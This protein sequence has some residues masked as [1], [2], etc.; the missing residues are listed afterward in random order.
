MP[1]TA[2][3]TGWLNQIAAT[4][5]DLHAAYAGLD[6]QQLQE[7][8]VTGDWSIRDILA[9]IAVWDGEARN[10]LPGIA[11]GNEDDGEDEH[12]DAFNA[13]KTEEL[14]GMPLDDVRQLMADTH[15]QLLDY[16]HGL[17]PE[18]LRDAQVTPFRERLGSDTWDHY[19]GHA[20]AIRAFREA[21]GW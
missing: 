21:R 17:K 6:D 16:L 11:A 19:P 2:D 4:W 3:T 8:G 18:D 20:A 12:I 7:P 1:K 9:H 13:R 15:R 5:D 10:A 14:R